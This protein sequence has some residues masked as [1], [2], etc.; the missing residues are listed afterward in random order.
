MSKTINNK[1]ADELD[2]NNKVLVVSQKFSGVVISKY[3]WEE[4]CEYNSCIYAELAQS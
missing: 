4:T 3:Y 1:L 2:S